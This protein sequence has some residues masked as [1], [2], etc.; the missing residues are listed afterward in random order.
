LVTDWAP[1]PPA[2]VLAGTALADV[3][4][5]EVVTGVGLELELEL[6]LLLQPAAASTAAA[7]AAKPILLSLRTV[8]PPGVGCSWVVVRARVA[9]PRDRIRVRLGR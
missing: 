8:V 4:G 1:S 3:T 6:E 9:T 2:P 5:V 7:T